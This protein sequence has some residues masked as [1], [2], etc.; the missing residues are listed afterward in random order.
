[1]SKRRKEKIKKE[2]KRKKIF[3]FFLIIALVIVIVLGS[4]FVYFKF[5]TKKGIE[6]FVLADNS[7]FFLINMNHESDQ[8]EAL[9]KLGLR[10]DD[11]NF[12]SNFLEDLIFPELREQKSDISDETLF[13]WRGDFVAL[14]NIKVSAIENTPVF[15]IEVKNPPLAQ[16]FLKT[17][18][19]N[20]RKRGYSISS[21]NFRNYNVTKSQGL[22]NISYAL[23]DNYL[24]V[25]ERTDGV[26]KM[27][28]TRLGRF[29]AL[30]QDKNYRLAKSKLEEE[31]SI[32]FG[33]LDLLDLIQRDSFLKK[34]LGE[35]TFNK[36]DLDN[37]DL[38]VGVSFIPHEDNIEVRVYSKN[39]AKVGKKSKKTDLMFAEK[40]PPDV[41]LYLEGK[42]ARP[43]VEGLLFGQQENEENAKSQRVLMKRAIQAQTGLDLDEDLLNFLDGEYAVFML[44]ENSGKKVEAVLIFNIKGKSDF[45][46][47]ITKIEKTAV[48]LLNQFAIKNEKEKADFT[49]HKYQDIGYRYL[50]LPEKWVTDLSL[51]A[52]S[53]YFFI[54]TSEKAAEKAIDVISGK[55]P[56]TLSQNPSFKISLEA[57][58]DKD[59]NQLFY[60]DIQRFIKFINSFVDFNYEKLDKKIKTLDTLSATKKETR[61]ENF[62]NLFLKIK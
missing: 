21:E 35:E 44:P 43:L 39:F 14:G 52:T 53:D 38:R 56:E 25:S 2:K 61:K 22:N 18:E 23:F 42:D 15:I 31:K 62:Y 51:G 59:S 37:E 19:E 10:F 30:A 6:S 20:L 27:I 41:I 58:K 55:I 3:G 49:D 24:L 33:Y 48:N 47:K 50:N 1:V 12:F 34:G 7:A 26:M 13:G 11:E 5:F 28:D 60:C 8:A 16:N 45:S 9:K 54:A 57:Q 36:L 17:L 4:F 32:I 29:S 46:E 40:I